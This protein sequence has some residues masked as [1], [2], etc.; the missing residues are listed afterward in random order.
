LLSLRSKGANNGW[1]VE[2]LHQPPIRFL[3]DK[4]EDSIIL[5]N[6][7]LGDLDL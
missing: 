3:H 4:K 5:P 6:P 1:V 7:A 2:N